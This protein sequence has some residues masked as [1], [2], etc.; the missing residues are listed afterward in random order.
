V[1]DNT[2]TLA[3]GSEDVYTSWSGESTLYLTVSHDLQKT[4]SKTCFS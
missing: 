3:V 2:S 1:K 4:N